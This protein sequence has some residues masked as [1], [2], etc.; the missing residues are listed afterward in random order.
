MKFIKI[1][2]TTGD[3]YYV[4]SNSIAYLKSNTPHG[5]SHVVYKVVLS[6]DKQILI[7]TEGEFNRLQA[8]LRMGQE[9]MG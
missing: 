9:A 1:I 5:G 4:N 8:H 7:P 2:D 6:N 3:A